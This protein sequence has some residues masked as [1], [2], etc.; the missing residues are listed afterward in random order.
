MDR[1][2][3]GLPVHNQLPEFIQTQVHRARMPS[4]HL[5]LCRPLLPLP[6]I[7]P[8]IRDFCSPLYFGLPLCKQPLHSASY[9]P[10]GVGHLSPARTLAGVFHA[11]QHEELTHILTVYPAQNTILCTWP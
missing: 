1:S 8:N 5:I 3:P 9:P 6:S 10:F 7:F 11:H 2:M 4:N